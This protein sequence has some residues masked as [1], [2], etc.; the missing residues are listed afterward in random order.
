MICCALALPAAMSAFSCVI[1]LP[2]TL[3]GELV[4]APSE[5][6]PTTGPRA[7]AAAAPQG[8][9]VQ[10]AM[11]QSAPAGRSVTGGAAARA[12]ALACTALTCVPAA[13]V[14]PPP[15][16]VRVSLS[17]V[18]T[19]CAS[20]RVSPAA[21]VIVFTNAGWLLSSPVAGRA[22]VNGSRRKLPIRSTFPAT[23]AL[24]PLTVAEPAA[25]VGE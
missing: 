10:F 15:G 9:T 19:K 4:V 3:Y 24:V 17:P 14:V 13:G 21:I 6:S 1:D 23:V 12:A 11:R 20:E 25:A 5:R 8:L 2:T 7:G 22:T 18:M 16:G